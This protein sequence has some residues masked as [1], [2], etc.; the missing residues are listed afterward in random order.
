MSLEAGRVGV[1]NDQVD[2]YGRINSNDILIDDIIRDLPGWT[3]MPVWRGGTEAILPS[4]DDEPETSPILA[5]IQYPD[6]LRN[7]QYFL[8]R[9][10]PTDVDGMAKI[11]RLQGNTLVWNQL[12]PTRITDVTTFGITVYS[13]GDGKIKI[14]GE[15]TS[16]FSNRSRLEK[17][18]PVGHKILV[19]LHNDSVVDDNNTYIRFYDTITGTYSDEGTRT[20]FTELDNSNTFILESS[21]AS[22]T[23]F[24]QYQIIVNSGVTLDVNIQLQLI[25]LTQ[26]NSD[27][28]TDVASFRTYFPL[29]YYAPTTGKLLPFMG[30]ELKTANADETETNVISLPTLD[31]F[32]TG[33]KSAGSLYDEL[34]PDKAITRIGSVI[35]DGSID[36]VSTSFNQG[37]CFYDI[38]DISTWTS[39]NVIDT[40][41]LS[42][43]LPQSSNALTSA[44]N[45]GI[46]RRSNGSHQLCVGLGTALGLSGLTA[47]NAY[48]AEHPLTVYYELVEPIIEPTII[49]E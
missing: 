8:Y 41:V 48:L 19:L 40:T 1:R 17:T 9:E 27:V 45:K 20:Y 4:N 21:D 10:S 7:N 49:I 35:L 47:W 28:I 31:F 32:P 30:E 26:L 39:T 14:S 15:A 44:G 6:A 11:R 38:S 24:D 34:L 42:D 2:A 18:I 33:M 13:I 5:D 36:P 12:V 25:D 3:D 43:Y 22:V 37:R 16:N 46:H 23:S 29:Q